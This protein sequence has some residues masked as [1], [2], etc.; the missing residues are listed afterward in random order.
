M[1]ADYT[2]WGVRESVK[3][4]SITE[5]TSREVGHA[6]VC[7]WARARK[8]VK[9]KLKKPVKLEAGDRAREEVRDDDDAAANTSTALPLLVAGGWFSCL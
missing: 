2:C 1:D 5:A 7:K 6:M 4:R 8:R 9:K 3:K